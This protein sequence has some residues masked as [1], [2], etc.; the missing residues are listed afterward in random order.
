MKTFIS[1]IYAVMFILSLSLTASAFVDILWGDAF[2]SP[3]TAVFAAVL[4]G[5]LTVLFGWLT[6][7]S[8]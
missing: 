5:G 8:F 1:V 7:N 4:L 3:S 2:K 6:W